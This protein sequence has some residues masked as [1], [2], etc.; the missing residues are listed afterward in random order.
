VE[1]SLCLRRSAVGRAP[2]GLSISVPVSEPLHL[3]YPL[4]PLSRIQ[5]GRKVVH[6]RPPEE[7][8]EGE[9]LHQWIGVRQS[10]IGKTGDLVRIGRQHVF[11]RRLLATGFNFLDLIDDPDLVSIS[12][13]AAIDEL[14]AVRSDWRFATLSAAK[15]AK[16]QGKEVL[17]R[18]GSL[19]RWTAAEGRVS[20]AFAWCWRR[21]LKDRFARRFFLGLALPSFCSFFQISPQ[22]IPQR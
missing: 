8:L 16:I 5:D 6:F 7:Q 21:L 3:L 11:V 9:R 18:Y 4:T 13:S 12:S 1:H 15:P 10:L 19:L 2:I 20:K 17:L 14:A 22:S